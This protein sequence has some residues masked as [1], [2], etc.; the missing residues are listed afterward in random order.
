MQRRVETLERRPVR[1]ATA[2]STTSLGHMFDDTMDRMPGGRR[3]W[4]SEQVSHWTHLRPV[5]AA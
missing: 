5:C 1:N 2:A 4:I 3:H